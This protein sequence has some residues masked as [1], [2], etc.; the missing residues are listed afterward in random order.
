MFLSAT[1]YIL[2]QMVAMGNVLY[3]FGGVDEKA[4]YADLFM[5][6]IGMLIFFCF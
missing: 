1:L 3:L 4:I 6:E 2:F 5:M